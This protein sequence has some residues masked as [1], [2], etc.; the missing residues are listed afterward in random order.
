MFYETTITGTYKTMICHSTYRIAAAMTI[1]GRID[2]I[3]EDGA[4]NCTKKDAQPCV[5]AWHPTRKLLGC[6]WA[7]GQIGIWCD[8]ENILREAN[9][10]QTAITSLEW[11]PNGNRL[12]SADNDGQVFVWKTDARGRL[13]SLCQYRLKGFITRCL[14][15]KNLNETNESRTT[16]CPPFFLGSSSGIV[17]YADDMGHCS[18]AAQ[19]SS[20]ISGLLFSENKE[21]LV[22]VSGADMILSQFSLSPDGK[23]T[24][25]RSVKLGANLTTSNAMLEFQW[26]VPGIIAYSF[27]GSA[28]RILDLAREETDSLIVPS[29]ENV[30]ITSMAMNQ[31][32]HIIAGGTDSGHIV[33]WKCHF[34]VKDDEVIPEW[35]AMPKLNAGG[36]PERISWGCSGDMLSIQ[37]KGS[38]KIYDSHSTS[39][40]LCG[41]VSAV[42]T[43]P[44][45]V[46]L[47]T[48]SKKSLEAI[49]SIRIRGVAISKQHFVVWNGKY[50]EVYE[51][52][53][54]L[55]STQLLG[56]LTTEASWVGIDDTSIYL[57]YRQRVD[58]CN[59]KGTVKQV[60]NLDESQGDIVAVDVCSSRL[61]IF[62]SRNRLQLHSA[63]KNELKLLTDIV[64]FGDIAQKEGITR[65]IHS[66][67]INCDGSQVSFAT[68]PVLIGTEGGFAP[69]LYIYHIDRNVT[70]YHEFED[71]NHL[72]I[73][74]HFWD[75][76]DPRILV[77]EMESARLAQKDLTEDDVVR[78]IFSF[79]TS[80]D[81]G[82]N[83]QEHYSVSGSNQQLAGVKTPYHYFVKVAQ[84]FGDS[85][86]PQ[87]LQTTA[88]DFAGISALDESS[89]KAVAEFRFQL[90]IGN[91]DE[92][93][94][95]IKNL[96]A[97]SIW[98]SLAKICVKKKRLDVATM[99]LAN[100]EHVRAMQAMRTPWVKNGD[101]NVKAA[102]LALHLGLDEE[103]PKLLFESGRL[104][105]L[106]EFYQS[107]GKW[108]Q[109]LQIAALSDRVNLRTTFYKFGKHLNELGDSLGAIAA[110]ESSA[111]AGVD[112]P[113]M[114]LETN[115]LEL[116][117]YIQSTSDKSLLRWWA[118]YTESAGNYEESL[119]YYDLA[120]DVLATVRVHCAMG[121][122]N[123]GIAIAEKTSDPAA[124]YFVAR[125]Q[126]Q[127][128]KIRDAINSF[129]QA[130]C[131]NLATKLAKEHDMNEELM[132]LALQGSPEA[133]IDAANYYTSF[134]DIERAITLYHK[135]GNISKAVEL[136]FKH[137]HYSLLGEIALSLDLSCD[138]TLLAQCAEF[139]IQNR[140]FEQASRLLLAS[141]KFDEALDICVKH[142]I[143][144]TEEMAD[145][146]KLP[147]EDQ[148]KEKELL[149]R[150]AE[151]CMRQNSY[152]LACKK[153]TQAGDRLN[154]MR[155][156]L[157]S[158]D[159]EKIIVFANA[160]GQKIPEIQVAAANYLQTLDW[161]NDQRIM[162][163]II[164]FYTK[165]KAFESLAGFYEACAQV[166]IDEYQNYE[167]AHGALRESIKCL[168][169]AKVVTNR[170]QKLEFLQQRMQSIGKFV[171]AR[172]LIKGNHK[173]MLQICE[174]LLKN[175]DIEFSVRTGD[176]YGL[177]IESH[178]A[179]GD[180]QQAF[181]VLQLMKRKLGSKVS[182]S[183]YVDDQ[184]LVA[185]RE[186]GSQNTYE[187]EN[188][189]P[190]ELSQ[191]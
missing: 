94:K 166:E 74:N 62:T 30:R 178:Y 53:Q 147:Q 185:L 83:L 12:V 125:Q 95:S 121:N 34:R 111:V 179:N 176:I 143:L 191:S 76:N 148:N 79:F 43:S 70:H 27:G 75:L 84:D 20:A 32:R 130:K 50:A 44:T 120:G 149:I 17:Y 21:I 137:G 47:V 171:E 169:K 73:V 63:S 128:G 187:E 38:I 99:C 11:G 14:F 118:Q 16:E 77:Y 184:I 163:A 116:E 114:L 10:H 81:H 165:A 57:R 82:V 93:L 151:C 22:V 175:P 124:F 145:A 29:M 72:T 156:L 136:C 59:H 100:I 157:K 49:T 107:C 58:I 174:G 112:I 173:E 69:R 60:V 51:F 61:A 90:S 56:V 162:K 9:A 159:T 123:Q 122:I 2:V 108:E 113:L 186:A 48:T 1:D 183:Y 39:W 31:E 64:L 86:P 181:E 54:E 18:E 155:A 126:E 131:F 189:I 167:K 127:E 139:F 109:A 172:S 101:V 91:M 102:V 8:Q 26:V 5:A 154:A 180:H 66:I 140:Q 142:N 67:R 190:E 3:T 45:K 40:A 152:H 55:S 87:L 78:E 96:K 103:V 7:S 150:V 164:A 98:E 65:R 132:H 37:K 88:P 170:E 19:V 97:R 134:S 13:W 71:S 119:K 153:F 105:I 106:N 41:N 177:M 80:V 89:V 138:R 110:Y 158:G 68:E 115:E 92:A 6:T 133:M 104:D 168:N 141:G 42:Q 146:M 182:L 25:E 52:S 36:L 160:S 24:P 144:L 129:S 28:I 15:R 35:Q 23:L 117:K 188:D 85:D 135:A 33:M 4:K 46:S 161:R